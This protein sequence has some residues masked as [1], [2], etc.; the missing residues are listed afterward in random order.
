MKGSVRSAL[1]MMVPSGSLFILPRTHMAASRY[2][3]PFSIVKGEG[4]YKFGGLIN[5]YSNF[6]W[7]YHVFRMKLSGNE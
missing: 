5:K 2:H 4:T 1:Q 6:Y 7:C 3:L